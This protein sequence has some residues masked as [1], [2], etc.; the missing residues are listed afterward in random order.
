MVP[1]D[2]YELTGVSDPR[3]SP[4]GSTIAYVIWSVDRE[5]N[6]YRSAIWLA[7][8]DGS[9]PPRR[10]SAGTKRD[11][12]PRWS[13]DGS[14]IAFTSTREREAAQLY[15][16]PA[17]GG[18]AMRLTDLK[19]DVEEVVWSPDGTR[20]AF[21]A[22]VQD[23]TYDES[24]ERKRA[25]RRIT[26]LGYKLDNVG[27]IADRRKHV[28]T[29]PADGSAPAEQLSKGEFENDAPTWSPDGRRIAFASARHDD[30]D[31]DLLRDV[32]V[33]DAG[34]GEP[35]LLTSTDGVCDLPSWSPDGTRIAY[36]YVEGMYDEPRHGQVAVIDLKTRRRTVLSTS[37]DRQCAPFPAV[38]EPLWDGESLLFACEDRG[39]LH[40]YRVDADGTS[41]P[42]LEIEGDRQVAG[43]DVAGGTLA[44][45]ATDAVSFPELYAGDRKLT[46][47]SKSFLE[48]RAVQPHE[49]FVAISRD[50]TEV[51]AWLVKPADFDPSKKYPVLLNV[52]GGPFTQYGNRFFDEFQVQ[53]NAG[54][55]VVFCNPR[56]S[57]G[58]SE[59]WGRAIRGPIAEGPGWGS[60][61][62]DDVMAAVDTA[63]Q[64]FSFCD[65][66]RL[67]VLGG[68][69]GGFMAT[70]IVGHSDRFKVAISERSVNNFVSEFGSSDFGH[71]FRWFIGAYLWEAYDTYRQMSPATYAP[72]ITTPLLIM[73]SERDLRCNVE[74]AEHLFAI[75][76]LLKKEV[77]FVRFPSESH[78]LSRSGSPLHR[79]MRFEIMLD[80]LRRYLQP[81]S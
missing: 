21:T 8:A 10:F 2:V 5:Q 64:K 46:D 27:W 17:A 25:P 41:A 19:E 74:Q 7:A 11:A 35:E 37:L 58:Y 34:G 73:H 59:E 72:N 42:S 54:Y 40:V 44:Y 52:H 32:F 48:T 65:G 55:V 78:E 56:G 67:G 33:V 28:F 45:C 15:V 79:V 26:R 39:N 61:D 53:A 50:G 13:P 80:W 63:V 38:R 76:R 75:M 36:L 31:I 71:S 81:E 22:R 12:T 18:E 3:V 70:W 4:D 20:I 6:D 60:V 1:E 68:S 30:W 14:R 62:Y 49:R 24:D 51:E 23:A 29:V 69:Y 57:S 9:A 43:F 47:V 66:E 16:I 77:E